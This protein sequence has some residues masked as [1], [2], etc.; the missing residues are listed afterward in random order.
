MG[1]A[2]GEV[3]V[4][5]DEAERRLGLVGE[6]VDVGAVLQCV[7]LARVAQRH[8]EP[9]VLLPPHE[10]QLDL[11]AARL[12]KVGLCEI[13]REAAE[14]A[15]AAGRDLATED[16]ALLYTNLQRADAPLKAR[17]N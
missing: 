9:P 8:I 15:R 6:V 13:V 4:V 1:A 7:L 10:L 11:G 14:D 16:A 12:A 17:R 2:V 5:A 3:A